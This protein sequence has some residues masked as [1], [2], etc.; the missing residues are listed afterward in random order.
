MGKNVQKFQQLIISSVIPRK[1]SCE[2][3]STNCRKASPG[4]RESRTS[5]LKPTK[6]WGRAGFPTTPLGQ[7]KTC[8]SWSIVRGDRGMIFLCKMF[9]KVCIGLPLVQ[10]FCSPKSPYQNTCTLAKNVV[11]GNSSFS[12]IR[13]G[14]S[15]SS[16]KK[17]SNAGRSSWWQCLGSDCQACPALPCGKKQQKQQT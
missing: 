7:Q 5:F 15:S 8:S 1:T 14:T 17:S 12:S 3:K 10:P 9:L 11:S 2:P 13:E 16:Q 6:P 4:L